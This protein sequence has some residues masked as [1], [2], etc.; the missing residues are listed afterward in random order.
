MN[1][2]DFYFKV[3]FCENHSL[4]ARFAGHVLITMEKLSPYPDSPLYKY[5]AAGN[6]IERKFIHVIPTPRKGNYKLVDTI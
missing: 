6:V 3:I 5:V 4:K 1:K 2:I